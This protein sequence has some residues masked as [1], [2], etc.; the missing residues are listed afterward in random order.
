MWPLI[1]LAVGVVLMFGLVC[2]IMLSAEAN[3]KDY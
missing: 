3:G 1:C 2:W